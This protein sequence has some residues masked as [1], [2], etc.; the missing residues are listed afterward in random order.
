M[1]VI[2]SLPP[3]AIELFLNR[4]PHCKHYAPKY[5]KLASE[6]TTSH[7][8]IKFYAVSCVAHKDLCKAQKVKSYPTLKFF[9]EGS[10]NVTTH[11]GVRYDA[12]AILTA[13]GFEGGAGV[14]D[15]DETNKIAKSSGDHKSKNDKEIARV[16]PF[17][18]H[19]VH[20]AW[21]DAALSF[22]F[23]LKN[24]IY[25][26]N[27]PL[28]QEKSLAFREW[29]EL[30]SKSLPSQMGRTHDIINALLKHFDKAAKGQSYMD[31]LVS[32]HVPAAPSWSWRTCTYGDNTMGYTCGLW[33]LFHVMSVGVVEYNRHNPPI[34]TRHASE[35]LR[36]YIDHF[37]Q[38]DVC[39]MNFLS[40]YDTCAFDGC[41]R[42]SENPSLLEQEWRE[43]PLWLW[44]THNDG[45]FPFFNVSVSLYLTVLMISLNTS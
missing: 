36:N 28:P 12:N 13:L 24:G 35:T 6:V 4:C 44:E 2:F 22:E 16:V 39:R 40:M 43:L 26:E 15:G 18:V 1:I 23:A 29:L 33:Q 41:H 9:R 17:R 11:G 34:P 30:L 38:C 7:P 10:Y 3:P 25:M 20:D 37:F 31:E 21:S 14:G 8:A 27:G 19:D 42:L 32:E 5:I 45:A